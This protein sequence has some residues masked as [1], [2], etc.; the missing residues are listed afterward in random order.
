[1]HYQLAPFAEVKIVRCQRGAVFDVIVDLRHDSAT[2]LQWIGAELTQENATM[3]Y[4]PEGCA[5][6]Y[7]TLRDD[8]ELS[9]STSQFYAPEAAK[10]A[11]YDDPLFEIKWPVDVRVISDQDKQWPDFTK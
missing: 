8:T 9:Y 6:G 7:I 2:Y 11:R 4:A 3:L 5:H 1:M 10:G